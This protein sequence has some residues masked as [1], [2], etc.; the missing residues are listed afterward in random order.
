MAFVTFWLLL[1]GWIAADVAWWRAA[2]RRVRGLR[3]G[4]RLWR[5]LVLLFAAAMAAYI[6]QYG[7][8]V[9]LED[10]PNPFPLSIHL[11]AYLWHVTV[12]PLVVLWM[13][14]GAIV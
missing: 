9:F 12:L 3:G 5:G 1:A 4:G 14:A 7:T 8:R 6:V 2:D 11:L 10:L 13:V